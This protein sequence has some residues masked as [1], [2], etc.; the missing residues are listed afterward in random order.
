MFYAGTEAD[1][2]SIEICISGNECIREEAKTVIILCVDSKGTQ[3]LWYA[4]NPNEAGCYSCIGGNVTDA[5]ITIA[6]DYFGRPVTSIADYAFKEYTGI[7]SIFIGKNITSIG[8]DAFIDC[9]NLKNV[10]MLDGSVSKIGKGAFKNCSGLVDFTIPHGVTSIGDEAFRGCS[11]LK[12]ITIPNSVTSIGHEA[13][14]YCSRLDSIVVESGNTKYYSVN[15]CIIETESKTLL[16]GN[17]DSEVQLDYG[18]MS[19]G[20]Y[21]FAGCSG[22]TSIVIPDSV[23]SIG[24][25]AFDGCSGLKTVYYEG[26]QEAWDSL[27]TGSNNECLTNAK[28]YVNDGTEGL[29]YTLNSDKKSYSCTGRGT[30]EARQMPQ[31]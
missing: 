20:A 19:I 6:N 16:R 5:D 12:S 25:F 17:G 21:A 8:V 10:T 26:G 3:G 4:S 9:T 23:T 27:K 29:V 30:A 28:I 24:D 13:F 2:D 22:I 31:I 7:K 18:I 1:W 15:N 14:A 11:G